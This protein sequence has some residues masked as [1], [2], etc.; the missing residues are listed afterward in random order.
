MSDIL[1]EEM[2]ITPEDT[3]HKIN[4]A[5]GNNATVLGMIADVPVSFDRKV[6]LMDFLLVEGVPVDIIVG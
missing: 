1:A 6:S 2:S 4:M 3:N 5:D